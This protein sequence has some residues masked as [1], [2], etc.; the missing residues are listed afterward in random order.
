MPYRDRLL[1]VSR[2]R[3]RAAYLALA[4]GYALLKPAIVRT[5]WAVA[6]MTLL[7]ATAVIMR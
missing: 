2:R 1:G 7:L 4:A 6:T 5:G 3:R